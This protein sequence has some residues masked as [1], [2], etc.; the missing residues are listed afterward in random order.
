MPRR[1]SVF[2]SVASIFSA[3]TAAATYLIHVPSPTGGYTHIGDTVIYLS[4]LLFGPAVGLAVG[5]I[6][7]LAADL[8][9]GYPRWYVTIVAHGLQGYIAG[10]GKG[11]RLRAQVMLIVAAGLLMSF[12]YFIVNVIIKGAELALLLLAG[13][14][15]G[16]SLISW[17]LS[18]ALLKPLEKNVVVRKA[19]SMI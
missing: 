1:I 10:L 5:V 14:I 18:L 17:L 9:V 12:T 15:F 19:A 16:Q 13:D 3:L 7:P 8:L 2:V 4:A 11:K 6:G